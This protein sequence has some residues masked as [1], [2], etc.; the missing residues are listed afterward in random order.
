MD[1]S[2][3]HGDIRRKEVSREIYAPSVEKACAE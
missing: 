1:S 3:V 2:Y